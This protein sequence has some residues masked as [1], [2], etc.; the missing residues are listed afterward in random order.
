MGST[1]GVVTAA[2][3]PRG[4]AGAVL[5][6]TVGD[7]RHPEAG[8]L[9]PAHRAR[10]LLCFPHPSGF[11]GVGVCMYYCFSVKNAFCRV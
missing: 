9:P 6:H 1:C 11:W 10:L 4:A 8:R 5:R 3:R 2:G 7:P